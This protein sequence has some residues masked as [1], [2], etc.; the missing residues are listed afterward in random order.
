M[1]PAKKMSP[2]HLFLTNILIQLFL[3]YIQ[4]TAVPDM[5]RAGPNSGQA[6]PWSLVRRKFGHLCHEQRHKSGLCSHRRAG[7]LTEFWVNNGWCSPKHKGRQKTKHTQGAAH[8]RF[9]CCVCMNGTF[10]SQA[11]RLVWVL[12][13]KA[14]TGAQGT[15][16]TTQKHPDLRKIRLA[17]DTSL[18]AQAGS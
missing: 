7:V 8:R 13:K 15:Q 18:Q 1:S 12:H 2:P 6:G 9:S 5:V 4:T 17:I 16:Q 14:K 3:S 11:S 10:V